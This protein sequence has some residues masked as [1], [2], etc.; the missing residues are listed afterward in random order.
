M[1]QAPNPGKPRVSM[2]DLLRTIMDINR[3]NKVEGPK[4]PT[5]GQT[6]GD[7]TFKNTFGTLIFA[8]KWTKAMSEEK[9]GK[10]ISLFT[11]PRDD[12]LDIYKPN[13][14]IETQTTCEIPYRKPL[15]PQESEL[16]HEIAANYDYCVP[17]DIVEKFTP[18]AFIS[19]ESRIQLDRLPTWLRSLVVFRYDRIHERY[20]HHTHH[21]IKLLANRIDAKRSV[22]LEIQE[23]DDDDDITDNNEIQKRFALNEQDLTNELQR[24]REELYYNDLFR[25][26]YASEYTIINIILKYVHTVKHD[27]LSIIFI[28]SLE[29]ETSKDA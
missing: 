20:G 18:K 7:R 21:Y 23:K 5:A 1:A 12:P 8:Q 26:K 15:P 4:K 3:T 16:L 29:M 9:K 24:R 28:S 17:L 22:N 14:K 27:T 19:N 6:G 13:S 10:I 2:T 11:N 25:L